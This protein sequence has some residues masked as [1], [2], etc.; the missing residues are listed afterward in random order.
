MTRKRWGTGLLN[1]ALVLLVLLPLWMVLQYAVATWLTHPSA[2]HYALSGA[3]AIYI[4]L[5]P[6]LIV[7]GVLQNLVL[8]AIPSGW[9]SVSQR[10]AA[11]VSGVLLPLTIIVFEGGRLGFLADPYTVGTLTVALLVYGFLVRIPPDRA[12]ALATG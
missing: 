2:D 11:I 12:R 3:L 4:I 8:L 7:G 1:L 6:Q 9:S 5:A 10:L